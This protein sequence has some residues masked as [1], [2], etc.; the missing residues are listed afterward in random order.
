MAEGS[1]STAPTLLYIVGP[2]AVGKATVG[3]EIATRT[4]LRLFHNH[5]AIEP[6]L[7]FFDFGSP[8][9]VRLVDGFRQGLI[10]EVAASDLP[11]LIFT[12]VWAFDQPDDER[13]LEQY[14]LPFRERGGRVLYL[15]LKAS[16]EARLQRNSGASRLAE[17]PSKRDLDASQRRLL[18][19]DE[20]HRLNSTTEF[21][22]RTDYLRIDNTHL[23]PEDVAKQVIKQ[24]SL[25]G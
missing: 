9:F 14:A 13:A 11:G 1:A 18:A 8:A 17:K 4:G 25:D 23:S 3:H 20:R 16:Q 12:Y 24:F 2:P 21:Q 10:E 6:V 22:D 19:M 15:E 7:R 5:M